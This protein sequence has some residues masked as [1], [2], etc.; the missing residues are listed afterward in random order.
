M[1]FKY[2]IAVDRNGILL[3]AIREAYGS[4][5]MMEDSIGGLPQTPRY[6]AFRGVSGGSLIAPP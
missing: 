6:D 1:T 2:Y 5:G 3:L 4:L